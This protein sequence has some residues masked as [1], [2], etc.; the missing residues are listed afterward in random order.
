MITA[1]SRYQDAVRTFATS[2]IYDEWGRILLD[3]D[4]GVPQIRSTTHEATYRLTIPNTAPPPP[5][6]YMVKDG[7]TMQYLAWKTMRRHSSWWQMAE[8]NPQVWYPLDIPIGTAL[9]IPL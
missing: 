8:A 6:E 4:S 9:R 2:H 5:L 3:G 1:D 7:E